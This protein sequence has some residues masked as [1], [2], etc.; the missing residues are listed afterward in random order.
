[1][2]GSPCI[3]TGDNEALPK[4][5]HDL[6]D[7]GDTNEPLPLDLD[8]SSR[9]LDGD[10][11]GTST[12]DMGA[13]EFRLPPPSCGNNVLDQPNEQCDG[14]DDSACSGQCRT[15]CTCPSGAIPAV[16]GWGMIL[17]ALLVLTGAKVLFDRTESKFLVR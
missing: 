14:T 8:E 9:V 1:M 11:D 10:A 2:L 6:D 13:Y 16:S 7:D 17:L 15:D 12:V 3:D 5:T 4:D